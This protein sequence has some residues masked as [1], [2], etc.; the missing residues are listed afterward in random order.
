M[1][2]LHLA[3][4]Q[5]GTPRKRGEGVRIGTVRFL[6]RGVPKKDYAKRDYFDVWFPTLAP[7]RVLIHSYKGKESD[8]H[9][10]KTFFSRYRRELRSNADSRQALQLL[11]ALARHTPL[12][13]GCY[14]EDESQCHRSVLL[15]EL[16]RV[17]AELP[18]T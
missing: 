8:S 15:K 16:T 14:C 13:I 1:K 4:F 12:C 6:P 10:R 9:A 11:A 5:I 7:S 2:N 17:A 3:T 18:A